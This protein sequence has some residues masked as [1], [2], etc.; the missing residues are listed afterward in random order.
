[1]ADVTA[2]KRGDARDRLLDLAERLVLDKGFGATSIDELI[3]GVGITKSGFFYHFRDKNALARALIERYIAN[4]AAILDAIFARGDELSDDPLHGFLIG[5]KLF[6]EMLADLPETHPGC[7]AASFVYQERLFSR[8]VQDLTRIAAKRWRERFAQRFRA[9]AERYPPKTPV[10]FDALAD[11]A[12]VIVD[13][14]I[15]LG[16]MY[17]DPAILPGQVLHF[18]NYVKLLFEP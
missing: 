6:A 15:T 3:A 9:I 2:P 7:L 4:D 12:N 13:G 1:M 11:M 14:G 10:D 5:L 17:R 16:K 18:R 8:D